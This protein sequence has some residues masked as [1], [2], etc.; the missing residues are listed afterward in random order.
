MGSFQVTL[1]RRKLVRNFTSID[2]VSFGET[3]LRLSPPPGVRLEQATTL[4]AYVAGTESNTLCCLARLGLRTA[5]LS[6]LPLTPVGKRIESELRRH[7]VNTDAVAWNAGDSGQTRL[8]IF[9]AEESAAPIGIQVYYDR[10]ASACAAVNPD[11]I[12]YSLV[13][14]ARLLHLTGITPA[15]SEQAQVVF[16][17]LLQRAYEQH[18]PISFDVNYR[19]RLWTPSEAAQGIELACRQASILLCTRSDAA[20]LWHMTGSP[21]A[22]L[23]QM[24][25]RFDSSMQAKTY[26][27]TLGSEGAAELRNGQCNTAPAIPTEGTFRFGSGDAFAAGYLYAWL[28]GDLYRELR[29][30]HAVTPLMMG[31]ALAALKRCIAGDIASITPQDVRAVLQSQGPARFR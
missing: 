18:I 12:N 25:Q 8:G 22:V 19:A 17:R 20:D 13:D 10:A 15:L 3:M 14:S 16:T 26:V 5:W 31:N 6:A 27:L 21:E 11:R 24:A 9:Y 2:V 1:E 28:N 29:D 7:G 4:Y 30:T 23:E